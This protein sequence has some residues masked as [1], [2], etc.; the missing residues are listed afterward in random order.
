MIKIKVKNLDDKGGWQKKKFKFELE[1]W[2]KFKF[3]F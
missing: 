1:Y 2:F 3:K